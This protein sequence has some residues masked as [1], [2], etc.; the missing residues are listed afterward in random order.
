MA[1]QY[2]QHWQ[3]QNR[4]PDMI[5]GASKDSFQKLGVPHAGPALQNTPMLDA[6]KSPCRCQ[7]SETQQPRIT[8]LIAHATGP[9][10]CTVHRP[11]LHVQARRQRREAMQQDATN[12]V[13]VRQTA[14]RAALLGHLPETPQLT[15]AT[16]HWTP[17]MSAEQAACG[18]KIPRSAR[19]HWTPRMSAA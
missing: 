3:R 17:C 16:G 19:G 14:T 2:S 7:H 6:K 18:Y 10:A 4:Q 9:L 1:A 8:A 11:E 12:E 15:A 13:L 5:H